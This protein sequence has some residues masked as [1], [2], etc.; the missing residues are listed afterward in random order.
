MMAFSKLYTILAD[1]PVG[2]QTFNQAGL[3]N[4]EMRTQM[5]VEHGARD[6][7]TGG[8]GAAFDWGQLGR[9]DLREIPRSVAKAEL[10]TVPN[11]TFLIEMELG[12]PGLL[13]VWRWNTGVYVLPV[14]GLAT[15]YATATSLVGASRT[16]VPPQCR[17]F[18]PTVSSGSAS[19]WVSTYTLSAGDFVPVDSGFTLALYGHV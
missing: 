3:N 7:V 5:A 8:G 13:Y 1:S 12:G 15:W 2:L 19:I 16:D 9:H 17:S 6:R 4:D 11:A 18:Y 14:F 10:V